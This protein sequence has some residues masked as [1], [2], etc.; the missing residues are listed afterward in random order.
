M[1]IKTASLFIF[2]RADII[3]QNMIIRFLIFAL[4]ALSAKA[5]IR[6]EKSAELQKVVKEA[7]EQALEKFSEKGLRPENLAV[8]VIDLRNES[9]PRS[10]DFRGDQKIYPAS[11]V[12]L[13]YL[14]ATHQWLKDGRIKDT[15]EIRRAMR[16]MIVDSSN[17]ATH[18]IVDVLTDATGGSELSEKE[19]KKWA[20]K[21]ESVNRYFHSLGY[22]DINVVQKT[23]CEDIYG[24]ERQFWNEGKNRNM[25]TTNSTARL[26]T[27]I[28]LGKAVD[29]ERSKQMLELMKRNPYKED[30]DLDSQDIGFTGLTLK[31]FPNAKLWSKA[32][33]T[34]VSR[35]DAA[36]IETAD[37]L[38]FVFVIFTENFAKE[39]QIIPLIAEKII[40]GLRSL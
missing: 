33:W 3:Y 18:F 30:N 6:I 23:Y 7:V 37:G 15:P 17:D 22:I 32:G 12:K 19:L 29:S 34:S 11:V 25:L 28:A 27:E 26:L 14:V 16:D 39:R 35:H 38:R 40:E 13:F 21:R 2:R 36:Y 20:Y 1:P 9:E 8:T 24:R 31:K 5:Q 10:G 4:L